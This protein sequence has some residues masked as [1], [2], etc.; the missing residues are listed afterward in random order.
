VKVGAVMLPLKK[1]VDAG[2]RRKLTVGLG[3]RIDHVVKAERPRGGLDSTSV[4]RNVTT[5]EGAAA[6]S[7]DTQVARRGPIQSGI[8][9]A[10]PPKP[11]GARSPSS[12]P[13]WL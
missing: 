5:P 12:S 10:A 6:R 8:R 3:A 13:A 7:A 11:Y 1:N 4:N 2:R 9:K